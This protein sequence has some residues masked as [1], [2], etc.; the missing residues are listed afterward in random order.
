MMSA[1]EKDAIGEDSVVKANVALMLK[2]ISAVAIAVYSFVTIKS[3]IDD[4]RNAN[5]RLH[6]EV[7]MNSE[8]RIK[9]PLENLDLYQTMPSKT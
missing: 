5:I 4:L 7:D 6:H 2:T 3:D 8:F 9:W 1:D